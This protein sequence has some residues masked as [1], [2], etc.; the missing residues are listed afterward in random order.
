MKVSFEKSFEYFK[1]VA[2]SPT[3]EL[4][5]RAKYELANYYSEGLGVEKDLAKAFTLYQEAIACEFN[6]A[7]LKIAPFYLNGIT[8]EKDIAKGVEILLEAYQQGNQEAK[9]IIIET[10][11]NYDNYQHQKRPSFFEKIKNYLGKLFS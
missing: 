3:S 10:F 8:V 7:R 5:G 2:D 1:L 11:T 4:C 6:N 9:N